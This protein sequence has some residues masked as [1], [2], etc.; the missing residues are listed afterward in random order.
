MENRYEYAGFWIRFWAFMIDTLLLLVIITPLLYAVYG[1]EMASTSS[2]SFWNVMI[3]YVM[4]MVA[5]VWLWR[6]RSATPGKMLL[7]LKIVDKDTGQ[8]LTNTQCVVRY[9]SYIL[10]ML[11]LLL[12]FIWVGFDSK[13][14]SFH[15]KLANTVVLK[16]KSNKTEPVYFK[17]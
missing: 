9:F 7:S 17:D 2:L 15:D 4:P 12:G 10:S 5:T 14:Q 13:K 3:Q 1:E 11:P 16:D 8:K 6:A